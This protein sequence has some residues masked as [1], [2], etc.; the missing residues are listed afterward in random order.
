MT[1]AILHSRNSRYLC[2]AEMD[3]PMDDGSGR[4]WYKCCATSGD[5]SDFID[6]SQSKTAVRLATS[7]AYMGPSS[8]GDGAFYAVTDAQGD[9]IKTELV[10]IQR[11]IEKAMD[12]ET[13]DR[14]RK[15]KQGWCPQCGG[16]CG[17][18]CDGDY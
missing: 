16:Y 4:S 15:L 7:A 6:V 5:G 17:R 14:T 18:N 8:R 13:E 1:R 3:G 9:E 2:Y 10:E 12:A 11:Q